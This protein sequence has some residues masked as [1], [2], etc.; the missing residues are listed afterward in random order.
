MVT[1]TM[2]TMTPQEQ[3]MFSLPSAC[4]CYHRNHRIIFGQAITLWFFEKAPNPFFLYTNTNM[5]FIFSR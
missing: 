1:M 3:D 4:L 2:V 5:T